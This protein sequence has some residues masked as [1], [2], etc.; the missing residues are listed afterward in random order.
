MRATQI[1]VILFMCV[2]SAQPSRG[3]DLLMSIFPAQP[4]VVEE[5]RLDIVPLP[6][7]LLFIGAG[8]LAFARYKPESTV[9]KMAAVVV[10]LGAF[11]F[12]REGGIDSLCNATP[13]EVI[14]AVSS[15]AYS[16]QRMMLE[17]LF[18][19]YDFF[20][21]Q[22]A[23]GMACFGGGLTCM[24]GINFVET[25]STALGVGELFD[26]LGKGYLLMGAGVGLSLGMII[27]SRKA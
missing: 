22:S 19:A 14:L 12:I 4:L 7:S 17:V 21:K 26:V 23:L 27:F 11:Q 1:L 13:Y 8:A 2:L 3:A 5:L 20:A 16:G 18:S 24:V 10:V 9:R 25:P 15:F 6:N